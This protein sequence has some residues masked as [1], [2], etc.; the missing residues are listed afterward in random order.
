MICRSSRHLLD[1]LKS[2]AIATFLSAVGIG[3]LVGGGSILPA[4]EFQAASARGAGERE[5][6]A[7]DLAGHRVDP[8]ASITNKAVVLI[9]L[10]VDCP[11]C[12]RY[13]PEIRRLVG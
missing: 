3:L 2:S 9:F 13:A 12:G 8:L 11:V 7:V 6:S 10:A 1:P 4:G 5:P